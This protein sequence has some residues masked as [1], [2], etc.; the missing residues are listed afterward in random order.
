[1]SA[2]PFVG[3]SVNIGFVFGCLSAQEGIQPMWE[4]ERNKRGGRWILNVQNRRIVDSIWMET[5]RRHL[6]S[7]TVGGAPQCSG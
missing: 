7:V 2:I 3:H 5:V 1:M 6:F 4:D